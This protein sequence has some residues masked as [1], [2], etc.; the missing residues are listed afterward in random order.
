MTWRRSLAL[1]VSA[2]LLLLLVG[3]FGALL[4][5]AP[6][7]I[8]I[9]EDEA[10]PSASPLL[11][12]AVTSARIDPLCIRAGIDTYRLMIGVADGSVV[13]M[14]MQTS[15]LT[16]NGVPASSIPLFDDGTHGDQVAGDRVFT[17]DGISL[18][19][20][21]RTFGQAVLRGTSLTF[22]HSDSSQET[23][24]P[25]LALTFHYVASSVPLPTVLSPTPDV[26]RTGH[27]VG[28]V[29]SLQ[30]SFPAHTVNLQQLAQR[31]YAVFPDDR[32]FLLLS[33]PFNTAGAPGASFGLIRNPVQGIGLSLFDDSPAYGSSGVLQGIVKL[34]W[35][36]MNSGTLNHEILHRW[37]A[38]LGPSLNLSAPSGSFNYR[39][40]GAIERDSTGFSRPTAYCGAFD[41]LEQVSGSTY[42]GWL[43]GNLNEVGYNDLELYLMGLV[44]VSEVASP[45]GALVQPQWTGDETLGD[46]R[47]SNYTA[48]GLRGVPT[49]E[50]VAVHGPRS[51]DSLG[52]QKV[53]KAALI[54]AYDRPLTAVELAYYDLA[55][56]EYEKETSTVLELTFRAATG[57]RG[58]L[59][60]SI[61]FPAG[62]VP[63]GQAGAG[64]RLNKAAGGDLLLSWSASC[65][66]TDD[67]YEV[68]EGTLQS[69]AS[70]LPR[71][72]TTG[73][74]TS[75]TLAPAAGSTY[76]V[77]VPRNALR[78]GSHGSRGD[79]SERPRGPTSCLDQ[80]IG[81]CE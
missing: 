30:G 2:G 36:N 41:H 46:I 75:A 27:A 67:D 70:H 11:A 10:P 66:T 37:A 51:P 72:C 54:V 32:D 57:G 35:A 29:R 16:Y 69:F 79:G 7:G 23:A 42:R 52:S 24:S 78:E 55:M 53:F 63:A 49:S 17:T 68:Y 13:S 39:H 71:L 1:P 76:Y 9:D 40:W 3:A 6:P 38:Y 48:T 12:P 65:L 73:G 22:V 56:Q 21:T 50:I 5:A 80:E 15:Q 74:A 60:T 31:Y 25:D 81:A 61:P 58:S 64:L 8:W 62:A 77:V 44:G 26:R 45:V 18:A 34:Y 4:A 20:M 59:S 43:D 33:F 28:I 19:S 14:S 47:Y